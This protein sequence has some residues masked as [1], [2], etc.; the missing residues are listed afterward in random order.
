M[1]SNVL[2]TTPI[3]VNMYQDMETGNAGDALTPP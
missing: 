2:A 1:N 3:A